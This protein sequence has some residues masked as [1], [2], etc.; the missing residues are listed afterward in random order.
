MLSAY[1]W[2]YDKHFL[3]EESDWRYFTYED[4]PYSTSTFEIDGVEFHVYYKIDAGSWAFRVVP[5]L[6]RFVLRIPDQSG[7]LS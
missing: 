6:G 5:G 2:V 4:D 1:V 3:F 7:R